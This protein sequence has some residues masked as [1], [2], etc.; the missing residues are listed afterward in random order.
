V[1]HETSIVIVDDHELFAASLLLA[2]RD[3]GWPATTLSVRQIPALLRSTVSRTS[4]PG[5]SPS[6][7]LIL[8]D[9]DLG[10]QQASRT[11]LSGADLIS[12]LRDQG[13]H[14]LVVTGS[15]DEAHI[16]AAI[17]NGALGVIDKSEDFSHLL[18][19][20][21]T[22]TTGQSL[23]TDAERDK[24]TGLDE[25]YCAERLER[26]ERLC[27]L[28]PREREVLDL[29]ADGY[30]A[31]AIAAHFVVSIATV[32]AQI[33]AILAKTKSNSQL[34]AA[35]LIRPRAADQ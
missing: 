26:A 17:S 2:L 8:L 5:D 28:T 4:R 20:V 13:W 35:A 3:A 21:R 18:A 29:I 27:G 1:A 31:A 11:R 19:A 33:R 14:V 22:A 7:G 24:W 9:L 32:R 10:T 23:I 15:E 30:R 16:A 25:R 34:E 6:T 12:E